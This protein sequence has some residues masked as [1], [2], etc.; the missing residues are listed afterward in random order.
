VWLP[1]WNSV[2]NNLVADAIMIVA[3]SGTVRAAIGRI[4]RVTFDR[5]QEIAFWMLVPT[6]LV[7]GLIALHLN[8]PAASPATEQSDWAVLSDDDIRSLGQQL[9]QYHPV[10]EDI[11]YGDERDKPLAVSFARAMFAAK[12]P[13]AGVGMSGTIIGITLGG[14]EDTRPEMN[15]IAAF[16]KTKLGIEPAIM[17]EGSAGHIYLMIGSKPLP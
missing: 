13:D 17:I 1:D 16:C 6:A 10:A 5:S 11:S 12:W 7:L 3:L 14:F 8:T 4:A 2:G 9:A 15:T